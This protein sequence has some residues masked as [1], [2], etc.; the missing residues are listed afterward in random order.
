MAIQYH[1]TFQL[2]V[3][4]LA[5]V[6]VLALLDRFFWLF[7]LFA[8]FTLQYI[9][10]AALF[11][12]YALC[13]SLG[14]EGILCAL[15]LLIH[16]AEFAYVAKNYTQATRETG[17]V[18]L[19]VLQSNLFRFNWQKD[20]AA[21]EVERIA[22][23]FNIF[24]I[25]EYNDEWKSK[26]HARLSKIFP[27][28]YIN[29]PDA[30]TKN[31]AIYSHT[32]LDVEVVDTGD[33]KNGYLRV[34]LPEYNAVMF[35]FHAYTPMGK[36]LTIKRMETMSRMSREAAAE[37]RPAFL[38]GD[39]NQTPYATSFQKMLNETGMKLAKFPDGMYPTWISFL[40][41]PFMRIPIDHMIVNQNVYVKS[42]TPI[43]VTGSDHLAV[44]NELVLI[45]P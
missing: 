32:P 22:R 38:I 42:R 41:T 20:E 26:L 7:E 19:K 3:Y 29:P 28:H 27:H 36:D 43:N 21:L 5:F 8:H 10:I 40:P 35:N 34:G 15:I 24:V 13:M 39:F 4:G 1:Y 45:T 44:G 37:K 12:I 33:Y 25:N 18:N 31:I 14:R 11:C 16:S 6:T 23:D 30:I 2:L 17:T 9:W